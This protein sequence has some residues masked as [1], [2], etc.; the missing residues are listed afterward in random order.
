[1]RRQFLLATALTAVT[2]TAPGFAQTEIDDERTSQVRTS[3]IND[4]EPGDIVITTAGRVTVTGIR[5]AVVIDSNNNLDNSGRISVTGGDGATAVAVRGGIEGDVTH[6]GQIIVNGNESVTDEDGDGDLDG[7]GAIGSDR[8]GIRVGGAQLYTGDII[9]T[10]SSSISVVGNDSAAIRV[11]GPMDGSLLL[12]GNATVVGDRSFVYDIRADVSGDLLLGGT[13][14]AVGE[15]S[16]A[17]NVTG[18]IGGAIRLTGS[19]TA[20]AY[21]FTGTATS[22]VQDQLDEDDARLS[23]ATAGIFAS[24]AG[25]LYISGIGTT[26]EVSAPAGNISARGSAPAL[27]IAATTASGDIA[28]GEVVLPAVEDDPDTED[29][30]SQDAQALGYSFFSRGTVTATSDYEGRSATA[31]RIEGHRDEDDTLYTATLTHGFANDGIVSATSYGATATSVW[32]GEGAVMPTV[33][34]SNQITATSIGVDGAARALVIDPGADVAELINE[35]SIFAFARD[36]GSAIAVRDYSGTLRSVENSGVIAARLEAGGF[37]ANNSQPE[38]DVESTAIDL[39]AGTEGATIRQYRRDGQDED[40][41]IGIF[42]DIR[43][44]S[45]DDEVLVEAGEIDGNIFFGDGADFLRIASGASVS[46]AL[47][48]SDSDLSLDVDGELQIANRSTA[49]IR[50]ARFGDGSRLVFEVDQDGAFAGSLNASGTVT[51]ESGARVTASLTQ[52]VGDGAEF[53]VLTAN[54]LV[55]EDAINEL[56]NTEAPY[57]Y[58]ASI[59]RNPDDANQLVLTLRRKTAEELGMHGNQAAQYEMAYGT[60]TANSDLGSA[61]ASL[62]TEGEFFSAYDQLL[63]EYAA[64]AIQFALASNDSALGALSNRLEAVR[65]SPEDTGGLWIQEFAFF[66]DR[67]AGEFSP[68]YRGHGIGMAVGADRPL[69]PFYA[70]GLN[71]VGAAAEISESDGFDDPMSALTAQ[72]GVY[73]GAE[74][75]GVTLDLYAGAGLDSFETTRNIQIAG[76]SATSEADWNGYHYTGS[77]RLGRDFDLAEW[78]RVTPSLSVDYLAMHESSYEESGGGLGVD[79]FI[80]ER[81]STSFSSTAALTFSSVFDRGNSWWA[82]QM[83]IGY[84]NELSSDGTETYARYVGETDMF[85]LRSEELPG[86]GAIFGLGVTAGSGYSTFALAYDADFRDDFVRHTARLVI[87]MVF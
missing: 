61:M 36:G 45:G 62:N 24:V 20:S 47:V 85:T 25:G 29:D 51:F 74:A 55:I 2:A 18:D 86:S 65:L 79:L 6:Q 75:G 43:L 77:A 83:R 53:V 72:A 37:A 46:G 4:G 52:L 26:D 82:P 54:E 8:V 38:S 49:N 69:G 58:R 10:S 70:V 39:S 7:P 23:G 50:E 42:G 16:G 71:F 33:F 48:D 60:W 34:N 57:L 68:G 28:L 31:I 78:L 67:A 87:R 44:G 80:D 11:E 13:S 76:F 63:P 41:D 21:R 9:T 30:E 64:S 35:G 56:E 59:S 12:D 27:L 22:S 73:A 81:D 84:R 15:D 1:M 14:S 3:T 19:L 17:L 40:A 5:P 32:M 66:A